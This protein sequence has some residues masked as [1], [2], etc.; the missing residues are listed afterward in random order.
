MVKKIR[1]HVIAVLIVVLISGQLLLP[2]RIAAFSIGE[3]RMVGEQ[4]LY[5]IRTEFKVLDDPDISQYINNLGQEVLH[6]I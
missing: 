5:T 3:E 6:V 4:L 2:V 1:D